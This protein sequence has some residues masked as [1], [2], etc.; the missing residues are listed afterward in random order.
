MERFKD[1]REFLKANFQVLD[2]I[3]TDKQKGLPFPPFQKEYD[4]DSKLIA[5][6]E[7]SKDIL[8]K[9]D[10]FDCFAIIDVNYG[11]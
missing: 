1:N 5:L 10:V 4:S 8:L 2:E 7:V 11:L 6:P 9:N 3:Q